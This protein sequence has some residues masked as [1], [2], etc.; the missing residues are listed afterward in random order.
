MKRHTGTDDIVPEI[1]DIQDAYVIAV[2]DQARQRLEDLTSQ[3][4]IYPVDITK[5][6][7]TGNNELNTELN[8]L[9]ERNPVYVTSK[10]NIH[11]LAGSSERIDSANN[12]TNKAKSDLDVSKTASSPNSIKSAKS[13]IILTSTERLTPNLVNG[14]SESAIMNGYKEQ[15]HAN[16]LMFHGSSGS[17]GYKDDILQKG[18][19]QNSNPSLS[20]S[21]D[22]MYRRGDETNYTSYS[23]SDLA[24]NG[25]HREM[26]IDC[27]SSFVGARKERPSFPSSLSR[28][29]PKGTPRKKREVLSER[30]PYEQAQSNTPSKTYQPPKMTPEEEMEQ[31]ERIKRYQADLKKRREEEERIAKE[32]EFLRT[33]LRGSKKLQELE[34][35]RIENRENRPPFSL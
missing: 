3:H 20:Q 23:D 2:E 12:N 7:D 19:I 29:S 17:I 27:P 24:D 1:D 11:A 14:N 34:E 30:R 35:R 31:Q 33:S 6:H 16:G 18:K 21:E 25:P 13:E 10:E 28:G 32:E 8:R 15:G 26:A 22:S 9:T 5:V 4:K